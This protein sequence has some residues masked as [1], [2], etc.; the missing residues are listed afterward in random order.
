MEDENCRPLFGK[1]V[2]YTL[3]Q[4]NARNV[5]KTPKVF[6]LITSFQKWKM[7]IADLFLKKLYFTPFFKKT[8]EMF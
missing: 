2:F 6:V 4:K 3:F 5:L 8:Q 7:K 1:I